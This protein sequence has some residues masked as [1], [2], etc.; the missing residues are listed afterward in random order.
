MSEI[1]EVDVFLDQ[2]SRQQPLLLDARSESE[3]KQGHIPSAVNLPLLNDEHRAIVGTTYKQK[4]REAAVLAGFDLVGSKFGD[5]VRKVH[6]LTGDKH[7]M[8]YCWRGGMRS[9]IMA[10]V[11]SMAGFKVTLLKGGYKTFRGW[12]L[13]CFHQ[14]K[15]IFII[16]G[17]TGSGKTDVLKLLKEHSEQVI[18][19][20]ALAHHKGSAFG[21]LGEKPQ[22]RSEQFENLL[23]LE[24]NGMDEDEILW[25]ENESITIGSVKIPNVIFECMRKAPVIEIKTDMESRV[26]RILDDYG[27][28]PA[29]ILAENTMKLQKRLG[30][31]RTR[32]AVQA[33]LDGDKIKWLEEILSYYDKTYDYGMSQRKPEGTFPVES[34][35]H[36]SMNDVMKKILALSNELKEKQLI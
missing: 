32:Q 27:K 36:E 30:E 18:D 35:H 8:L 4:G 34:N 11:L 3:F 28:F 9:N 26:K 25:L 1:L 6:A 19:L 22:P 2:L 20:E 5:V 31:L 15:K 23:A 16:G 17:R 24:W 14:P 7:V 29:E 10:W 12:V 21:A 33:L 13:N